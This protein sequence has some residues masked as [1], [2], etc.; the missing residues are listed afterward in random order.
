MGEEPHRLPSLSLYYRLFS[1]P[2]SC[3]QLQKIFSVTR[4]TL[5]IL[6][7]S[8]RDPCMHA[9]LQNA[10]RPVQTEQAVQRA[11]LLI[12]AENTSLSRRRKTCEK[13]KLCAKTPTRST[14]RARG[15]TT[16]VHRG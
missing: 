13:R 16:Q 15:N 10:A 3:N 11:R 12:V 9:R 6:T 8:L 4:R 2:H 1:D 14:L 5:L 7:R